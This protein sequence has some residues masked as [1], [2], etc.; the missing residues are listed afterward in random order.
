MVFEKAQYSLVTILFFFFNLVP[1]SVQCIN[2]IR[3]SQ[4]NTFNNQKHIFHMP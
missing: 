2:K 4:K 1:M 3:V